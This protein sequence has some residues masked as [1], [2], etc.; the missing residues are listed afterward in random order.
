MTAQTRPFG[1]AEDGPATAYTIEG[2]DGV[3]VVLTD[4]G[5]RIVSFWAPDRDGALRDVALGFDDAEGFADRGGYFG[6]TCGRVANRIAGARCPFDGSDLALPAN[7]PPHHIH[8]GALGFD[9]RNWTAEPDAARNAVRFARRSPAGEEGYPGALDAA[10]EYRLSGRTLDIEMTATTDAPTLVNM[11][12]HVYWNLAGHES[13]DVLDQELRLDAEFMTPNDEASIPT[14]EILAVAGGPFDFRTAKTI[15]RDLGQIPAPGWDHNFVVANPV[16]A[17]RPAAVA[18]D[19][20]S[21]RR[22]T[23][24]TDQPGVQFYA[25][26]KMRSPIAKDGAVYGPFAGFALET[27]AF[28]D[29]PNKPHFPSIRLAPGD[30]YRH[31]MRISFDA[32]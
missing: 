18:R 4:Y 22:M 8:G 9:R 11:V 15:G 28:P 27:Q 6:A 31:R 29:A 25:G 30:A 16:G 26:G 20:A 5:A 1:A 2:D 10:V 7:R 23:I 13:G 12:N 17:L 21:G 32:L 19:P 3:R 14:G 24:E